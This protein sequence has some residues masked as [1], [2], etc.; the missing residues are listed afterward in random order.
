MKAWLSKET[1][2]FKGAGYT[3]ER[4]LDDVTKK[5]YK[6][7]LDFSGLSKDNWN[8]GDIWIVKRIWIFLITQMQQ[9]YNKLINN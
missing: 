9:T 8:P 7:A 2:R 5:I 6:N 3:Y 4:Q 1:G